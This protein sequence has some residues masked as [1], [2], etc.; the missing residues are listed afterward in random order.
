MSRKPKISDK[1]KLYV[2]EPS[3]AIDALVDFARSKELD[4]ITINTLAPSLEDVFL[5]LVKER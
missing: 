2:D 1:L 4:I 5:K 3:A